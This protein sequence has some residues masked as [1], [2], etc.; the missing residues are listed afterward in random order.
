M[1]K[2]YHETPHTSNH[3]GSEINFLSVNITILYS[4]VAFYL[5]IFIKKL[6]LKNYYSADILPGEV[7]L[8]KDN[9]LK[10]H[11]TTPNT[12]QFKSSKLF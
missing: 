1:V 7:I 11:Q 5:K 10:K 3:F 2:A 8:L 6:Y 4:E 12:E 9:E